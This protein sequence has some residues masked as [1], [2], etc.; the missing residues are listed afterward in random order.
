MR[1]RT[2][3]SKN[4]THYAIIKD[5]T[6]QNKRTTKIVENLGT[7]ESI[8]QR[9]QGQDPLVWLE[10]Y[11]KELNLREA[12]G[13]LPVSI[14]FSPSNSIQLDT[15]RLYR[16]G[17][18]FL[19][20]LYY[21][22]GLHRTCKKI[23]NRY[24]FDFDLNLI[25][26]HLITTRIIQPGS[27]AKN[28]ETCKTYLEPSDLDY[29]KV[30]RAL[31]VIAKENDFIQSELYK[32]SLKRTNRNDG[33]LYY[34]CTNY[35]FAINQEDDLRKYGFNKQHQPRPQV[36]MGLFLDGDGIPLAFSI[37][38]GNHN[39]QQSLK[40][41]E[42][43]IIK[44]FNH[45]KFVVCTD[46]GLSSLE[47]RRFNNDSARAF[48]TTQSVKMLK[49]H[50]KKWSLDLENDW[51]LPDHKQTYNL[52]K[53]RTD[54]D[55]IQKYKDHVFYKERW[56]KEDGLE[57]RLII[58]YSV[59]YQEYQKRIRENQF[60]R[61]IKLI[62]S[63]PKKIGKVR[64]NDFKRFIKTTPITKEG[65]VAS[66]SHHDLNL[67]LIQQEEQY[68]GIYGV[69]TNLEDSVEDIIRINRG[70]WEIEESFLILKS[71]FEA[72]PVHMSREDRIRAHFMTCFLAL[73]LFRVLEK[74]LKTSHS[75]Y[76]IIETLRGFNFLHIE[77]EGFIPTYNRTDLTDKLH[78]F[79][80]ARL[81][82]E[83][84]TY[85]KTKEILRMIKK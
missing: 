61:A 57:Q 11:V 78:D 24:K 2:T 69:C 48:V 47:N 85:K 12:Q 76:Q 35:F 73:T 72:R 37:F 53:L 18:L 56:I 62:E 46:A 65:E 34:D 67:E 15:Q 66:S 10:E 77:D 82:T 36:Q 60:N 63:K 28:I 7:L 8:A 84:V 38:P 80:G 32:N 39:E 23:T 25:L 49:G 29:H 54:P 33:V 13:K 74:E 9:A 43:T 70:R 1:I 50:L 16:G 17:Y 83:I 20:K 40:P 52:S 64:Q 22:L 79:L 59:R 27:K 26:R 55:L 45:S 19:E 4:T 44:D 31:E 3:S 21:D 75:F 41:L 68:D 5:V 71:E 14:H 81:D 30:M 6:R 51:K 42:Q 58:T